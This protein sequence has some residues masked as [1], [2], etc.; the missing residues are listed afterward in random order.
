MRWRVKTAGIT[1]AMAASLVALASACAKDAG[2]STVLQSDDLQAEPAD[3]DP[4]EIVD[5]GSFTDSTTLGVAEI[6]LFLTRTPYNRES[7]LSTYQSNGVRAADAIARSANRY[8]LNPLFFLV[9]SEMVQGLVGAQYYPSTPSRVE[10]VF[11]CGCAGAGSCDPAMAGFDRQVDCIGRNMRAYIDA[12]TTTGSTAGKWGTGI[13]SVT[14]DGVLVTPADASTAA[15]YQL[16]PLVA[17]KKAGG[18]WLFWNLWQ[19]YALQMNYFGGQGDTAQNGWIGDA[20]TSDPQCTVPSGVCVTNYPGGTCSVTCTDQCPTDSA[21]GPSFCVDF[22][23]QGG[24][25]LAVC[26]PGAPACRDGYVCK[27]QPKAGNSKVTENVCVP[28]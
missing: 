25:C 21:H 22:G 3:F 11:D 20:C 26:N 23:T 5:L 19:K 28:K 24:Y 6:Q 7:F 4:N 15:L 17:N 12:V 9:R 2:E 8:G 1:G 16:T 27:S 13:E 10:Y 18:T 14:L